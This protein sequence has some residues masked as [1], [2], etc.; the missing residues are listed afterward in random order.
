MYICRANY[1]VGPTV[2]N[3]LLFAG[4]SCKPNYLASL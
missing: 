1:A 4:A 3:A 2:R